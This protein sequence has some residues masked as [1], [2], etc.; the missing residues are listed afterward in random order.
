MTRWAIQRI[1][2]EQRPAVVYI[3]PYELDS[4]EMAGFRGRIPWRLYVTQGLNR[5]KSES[6]L[7]SLIREFEFAPIGEVVPP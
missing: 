3:H 6:K 2:A 7:R 5:H 1:N 4:D